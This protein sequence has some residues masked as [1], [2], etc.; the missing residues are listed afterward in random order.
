MCRIFT[1]LFC[2]VLLLIGSNCLA[3]PQTTSIARTDFK[4]AFQ[5]L[6]DSIRLSQNNVIDI[7]QE[8]G[9]TIWF[10]SYNG[11]NRFD[12]ARVSI[13]SRT[14][15]QNKL[16]DDE[17]IDLALDNKG[18]LWVLASQNIFRK[19][20]KNEFELFGSL[21]SFVPKNQSVN[22]SKI[23]FSPNDQLLIHYSNGM[24]S[25]NLKTQSAR[26]YLIDEPEQNTWVF[27]TYW[28]DD[29]MLLLSSTGL[30]VFSFEKGFYRSDKIP[31]QLTIEP[32]IKTI[33]LSNGILIVGLRYL[34][35]LNNELSETSRIDFKALGLISP[36]I[37]ASMQGKDNLWL[38]TIT[39][40]YQLSKEPNKS[41]FSASSKLVH[42]FSEDNQITS[43]YVDNQSSLWVGRFLG[44]VAYLR[45]SSTLF[46]QLN[47]NLSDLPKNFDLITS[48]VIS[49]NEN[50]WISNRK[51]HLYHFD[52]DAQVLKR[53]FY[54][55]P[56]KRD[57]RPPYIESL[58]KQDVSL[59]VGTINGLYQYNT[60]TK[61]TK[62]WSPE[63]VDSFPLFNISEIAERESK[64][65]VGGKQQGGVIID[66]KQL[67]FTRF[68][69]LSGWK[70][71]WDNLNV[72]SVYHHESKTFLGT[73]EGIMLEYDHDN[74]RF[75][76]H[77]LFVNSANTVHQITGH[78][79]KQLLILSNDG[80]YS[81][82]P[83]SAKLK[84]K[85][86]PSTHDQ[87]AF[88]TMQKDKHNRVWIGGSS[89]VILLDLSS[90][91]SWFFEQSSGVQSSEFNHA[92]TITKSGKIYLGGVEG[93]L[94]IKPIEFS[95]TAELVS[96]RLAGIQRYNPQ[97]PDNQEENIA[98]SM[99]EKPILDDGSSIRIQVKPENPNKLEQTSLRYRVDNSQWVKVENWEILLHRYQFQPGLHKIEVQAANLNSLHW[100]DSFQIEFDVSGAFNLPYYLYWIVILVLS[101]LF[102]SLMFIKLNANR[103]LTSQ[104]EKLA[105]DAI[106]NTQ[107]EQ[108]K[109]SE[110]T[111]SYSAIYSSLRIKSDYFL[112]KPKSNKTLL[113]FM[114]RLMTLFQECS[115][116]Y[117][118]LTELEVQ[119]DNKKSTDLKQSIMLLT[120]EHSQV[121]VVIR[122]GKFSTHAPISSILLQFNLITSIYDYF[123]NTNGIN[124]LLE[125]QSARRAVMTINTRIVNSQFLLVRNEVLLI[126]SFVNRLNAAL[127]ITIEFSIRSQLLECKL[128]IEIKQKWIA[129]FESPVESKS[130]KNRS[131][132]IDAG[133]DESK[134]LTS[135][136]D[137]VIMIIDDDNN[138]ANYAAISANYHLV[139]ES[140][141][142]TAE[143]CLSL[144]K[145]GK[146]TFTNNKNNKGEPKPVDAVVIYLDLWNIDTESQIQ[147]FRRKYSAKIVL[148]CT[149]YL[150]RALVNESNISKKFI[151]L[152]SRDSSYLLLNICQ[153]NIRS[154]PS[155]DLAHTTIQV[156]EPI[157]DSLIEDAKLFLSLHYS[158]EQLT[159][160]KVASALYLTKRQLSRHIRN[161]TGL[162]AVDFIKQYRVLRSLEMLKKGLPIALVAKNC[163]F[164]SQSYFSTCF[165]QYYGIPPKKFDELTTEQLVIS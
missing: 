156:G 110:L 6:P 158:D 101:I 25:V 137:D 66:T 35:Y 73:Y 107:T 11:L 142:N 67:S 93:L 123:G 152:S 148:L 96:A 80:V 12:G 45:N 47:V 52:S 31:K 36:P 151:L 24:S 143:P 114:Q 26:Q 27:D 146:L 134:T 164:S 75:N 56:N 149:P 13:Y 165:K 135:D 8:P 37:S 53:V 147:D 111:R 39:G 57:F 108:K 154:V 113:S 86:S 122:G 117:N 51:G 71:E 20:A 100:T 130:Y 38:G 58:V 5:Q 87:I 32:A 7:I 61:L 129:R 131:S 160:D 127:G 50:L 124:I 40:L 59:W 46:R 145:L 125:K 95:D 29:R 44:G 22:A 155:I 62:V 64:L 16:F 150:Y 1:L 65:W 82:R 94:Q 18:N 104:A 68:S 17:I 97:L 132:Q 85:L 2:S 9:G 136:R 105:N 121:N 138:R 139:F 21:N 153:Y 83:N 28:H 33:P 128:Y 162:S 63:T 42:Y 74:A 133:S 157:K 163:G 116:S 120:R 3:S 15:R 90:E 69:D 54:R 84:L 76:S 4:H 14:S 103:R 118:Q 126:Q 10:G 91:K 34:H 102:L 144:N 140:T 119:Q 49:D 43:L 23:S 161:S 48:D 99:H 112:V 78:G 30:W 98:L 88:F 89:G 79:N 41:Q 115:D 159:L 55:A 72:L 19:N 109:L 77:R 141:L 92:H 70:S 81:Y 60:E 106:S